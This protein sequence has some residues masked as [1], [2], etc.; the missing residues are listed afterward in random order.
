MIVLETQ[1]MN[2]RTLT[3]EDTDLVLG[4]F[5]DPI[6]TEFYKSTST[7]QEVYERMQRNLDLTGGLVFSQRVLLA[8]TEKG[9]R[10]EDAYAV[11][12]ENA[13]AAWEGGASFRE[14]VETDSRVLES[15]NKEEIAAAFDISY[16]LRNVDKIFA[17]VF[18]K[19]TE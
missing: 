11:V 3:L 5:S 2:L 10:R 1:R 12:Q 18:E 19:E 7:R 8:L 4:I 15:G 13:L 16:N 17:R 9:M 6:A 14:R